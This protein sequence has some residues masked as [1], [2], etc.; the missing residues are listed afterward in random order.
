[1]DSRRRHEL[2]QNDLGNWII[3]VY[4]DHIQPN[5]NWVLYATL[6]IALIFGIGLFS[7]RMTQWNKAQAWKNY[8]NALYS[9]DYENELLRIAETSK[10]PVGVQARLSLA[11]LLLGDGCAQMFRGQSGASVNKEI[12]IEQIEKALNQF[13]IVEKSGAGPELDILKTQAILGQAQAFESLAAIQDEKNIEQAIAQYERIKNLADVGE[14]AT[15]KIAFLSKPETLAFLNKT[16]TSKTPKED[17]KIEFSKEDPF[18]DGVQNFDPGKLFDVKSEDT[19]PIDST[20][21]KAP[22]DGDNSDK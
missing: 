13:R 22:I 4:E 2:S 6:A 10:G 8:Y 15:Y 19:K 14:M 12:A 17:L 1:M 21:S 5:A 7:H 18:P 16:A 3:T 20:P 9:I 11:Q